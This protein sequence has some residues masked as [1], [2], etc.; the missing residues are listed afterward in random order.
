M[1]NL[2]NP[3]ILAAGLAILGLAP[4]I[5]IMVSSFVKLVVVM[6]LV[7]NAL[8][9]QQVPPN[10]AINGLAIILSLYIM[11][12]VGIAMYDSFAARDVSLD[13]LQNPAL[14]TAV[15]ESV[16]PVR[17]FLKKHSDADERGFFARTTKD[18]WPQ[19][20]ADQVNDEHLLVLLP[21]FT[22]S[23]LS[24][25]FEAGFLLYLPFI[26]IDL[27]VSNVLLAMGMIMV[28]PMMISLPFK[29]LLFVL[30]DGWTRL[31][32]GLVLSYQ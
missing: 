13:D 3:I 28:S 16:E 18:I 30:A 17:D 12:P 1:D 20:Y 5:A 25:A 6:Y 10:L 11:A 14:F 7:R 31:I 29:I 21:A 24:A 15:Q 19:P 8:G 32:H 4:F 27:I 23:E 22:V 2:P 9:V 26:A